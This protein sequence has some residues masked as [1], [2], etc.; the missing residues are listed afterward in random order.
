M[1]DPTAVATTAIITL[2]TM[3]LSRPPDCPG[4]GVISVSRLM[5][6]APAPL[7]S[8]VT[9][10]Q[11]SQNNPNTTAAPDSVSMMRLKRLRRRYTAFW[12]LITRSV[13]TSCNAKLSDIVVDGAIHHVSL[14]SFLDRRSN[15]SLDSISTTVVIRNRIRPS[16]SSA[17]FCMPPASLNS[18][19]RADAIEFDGEN[20]EDG[21][22]N[23]LPM[24]NVTAMV[25]PSARPRPSMMPPITPPLVKGSTTFQT[26]SHVVEPNPYADSFSMGGTTSKTSRMTAVMNGMTMMDRIRPA[27]KMPMPNGGPAKISPNTG[28]PEKNEMMWG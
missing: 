17:D 5:D 18:L 14:P 11:H 15:S 1:G 8:S 19:A 10:I 20:R 13:M 16:S 7:C 9:I 26:T 6:T 25:S 12:A 23:A 21:R 2:P 28:T 4:G 24:T 3:A 22:L 27:V